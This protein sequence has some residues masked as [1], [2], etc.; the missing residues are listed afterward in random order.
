[1]LATDAETLLHATAGEMGEKAQEARV[2]LRAAIEKASA[3][4]ADLQARTAQSARQ[5]VTTADESVRTHPYQS[6]GCALGL[7]V[8]LGFLL[9]RS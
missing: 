1:M 9:R 2:R 7:G 8:L 5:I 3:T 4:C 6:I